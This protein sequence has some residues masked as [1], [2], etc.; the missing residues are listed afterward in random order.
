MAF[1]FV[2]ILNAY[3][4]QVRIMDRC[5]DVMLKKFKSKEG[6]TR[7]QRVAYSLRAV[8]LMF[9]FASCPMHNSVQCSCSVFGSLFL[10]LR[11][12][13]SASPPWPF[14]SAK[15]NI[16]RLRSTYVQLT[17]IISL[18]LIAK[19]LWCIFIYFFK[20]WNVFFFPW[21][22]ISGLS[23]RVCVRLVWRVFKLTLAIIR[24][25]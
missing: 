3:E 16:A 7:V 21:C 6:E 13:S 18:S 12:P 14:D 20:D 19:T 11:P 9:R 2:W 1:A 5:F 15:R 25:G 4:I 8:N 23:A 10:C 17:I 24:V 22:V